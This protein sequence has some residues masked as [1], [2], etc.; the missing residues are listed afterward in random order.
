LDTLPRDVAH[1]R[2][3]MERVSMSFTR[4]LPVRTDERVL[5]PGERY[6][7]P[8]GKRMWELMMSLL[9]ATA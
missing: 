3:I 8:R 7:E 5:R 6:L 1:A 2:E 4:G 9:D